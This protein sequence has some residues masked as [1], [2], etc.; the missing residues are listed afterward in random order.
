[1]T[2]PAIRPVGLTMESPYL[3]DMEITERKRSAAY[4][5]ARSYGAL[6]FS[7]FG[8]CWLLLSAYA[9]GTL[10]A[11]QTVS[12]SVLML[13]LVG[14]AIYIQSR[15]KK[16]TI[17]EVPTEQRKRDDRTFGIIN[18]V[19]WV[20]IFLIFTFFPKLGLGDLTFPAVLLVV[21]LHFF[22][23]PPSYRHRSNFVTG[24]AL[25]IWAVIC[26]FLFKGDRM[27]GFLALGAGLALLL[28]AAWAL[29]FASRQLRLAQL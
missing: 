27:I 16:A 6:F 2:R 28:S 5:V 11:V 7:C 8:G 15:E 13:L 17:G 4:A 24:T 22:L 20:A 1:M 3:N 21:G 29:A 14:T 10:R 18:A 26:P 25:S 19:Q 9:F 12:I 23:M